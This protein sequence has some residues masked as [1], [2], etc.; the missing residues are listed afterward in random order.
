[1]ALFTIFAEGIFI[2]ALVNI[3]DQFKIPSQK[4]LKTIILVILFF[5]LFI[6][7]FLGEYIYGF[8]VRFDRGYNLLTYRVVVWDFLATLYA[9]LEGIICILAARVY[10]QLK[11]GTILPDTMNLDNPTIPKLTYRIGIMIAVLTVV[12]C[13]FE[14]SAINTAIHNRFASSGILSMARFY[15][16]IMGWLWTTFEAVLAVI[17]IKIL[18][19]Q[20]PWR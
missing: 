10:L 12:F 15:R 16:I 1:M 20:K 17:L 4:R 11:E 3:S 7:L 2:I 18:L 14:Y 19:L 9:L 13:L 6:L 8:I 5:I